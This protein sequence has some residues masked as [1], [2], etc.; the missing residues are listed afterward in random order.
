M[1]LKWKLHDIRLSGKTEAKATKR[2]GSDDSDSPPGFVRTFIHGFVE[3]AARG[4][5]AI[6]LPLLLD[7]DQ[8]PLPLA[9]SEVL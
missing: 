4:G 6:L 8:G 5:E 2:K 7:V 9:K 3:N 1:A